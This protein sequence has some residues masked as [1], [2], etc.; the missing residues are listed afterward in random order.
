MSVSGRVREL[1]LAEMARHELFPQEQA[2]G[3]FVVPIGESIVTVN[4]ENVGREFDQTGDESL[5]V[6]FVQTLREH[7][8][9]VPST[10]E[11]VRPRVYLTVEPADHSFG[12]TCYQPI[13]EQVA[14]VLVYISPSQ[15]HIVWLTPD[16]LSRLGMCR[17]RAEAHAMDNLARLLDAT[18]L[19]TTEADGHTLGMLATHSPLKASLIFA[20]NLRAKVEA[21]LGWPVL[22]VIPNRD[23]CYLIPTAAESLLGRIGQVVVSEYSKRGY[24]VSTEVFRIDDT[25]PKAIGA[26]QSPFNPPPGMRAIHHDDMLTFFLPRDWEE[27][28]DG[29]DDPLYFDPADEENYLSVA[30]QQFSSNHDIPADQPR[31]CLGT[32]AAN[33][34]VEVED[35]PGGRAAIHYIGEE[36]EMRVWTW[37]I[38]G[39]ISPRRLGLAVFSYHEPLATADSEEAAARVAMLHAMLPRCLFRDRDDDEEDNP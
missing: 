7:P 13:S 16:I 33:E 6:H 8:C 38:C 24:P 35:W 11:E 34:G 9:L 26:F 19:E 31:R 36:D 29:N 30:T 3:T 23:F 18:P 21:K 39:P 14:I 20:P 28:E 10:W 15:Q 37:A 12:D 27:G 5:I 1:F 17:E 4:L 2:D 25:G 32:V 22:A